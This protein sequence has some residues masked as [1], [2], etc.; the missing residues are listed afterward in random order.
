VYVLHRLGSRYRRGGEQFAIRLV[1]SPKHIGVDQPQDEFSPNMS[2][3]VRL[4][5]SNRPLD[6]VFS[7]GVDVTEAKALI[8]ARIRASVDLDSSDDFDLLSEKVLTKIDIKFA[9]QIPV[10]LGLKNLVHLV[11]EAPDEFRVG[12]NAL[13]I[14]L[15]KDELDAV[16]CLA[17]S[18]GSLTILCDLCVFGAESVRE[19]AFRRTRECSAVQ[20]ISGALKVAERFNDVK[21]DT[22]KE[23]SEARKRLGSL[24]SKTAKKL[25]SKA[26]DLDEVIDSC[27][28]ISRSGQ[29][30]VASQVLQSLFTVSALKQLSE[31]STP[32]NPESV[33]KLLEML[34]TPKLTLKSPRAVLLAL[35]ALH[36]DSEKVRK[37]WAKLPIDDIVLLSELSV[38]KPFLR[39]SSFSA[40]LLTII[41]TSIVSRKPLEGLALI[42]KF[43]H[44][45]ISSFEE[46]LKKRLGSTSAEA[47]LVRQYAAIIA[48][49]EISEIVK[50]EAE[51]AESMVSEATKARDQAIRESV[52]LKAEV[53]QLEDRLVQLRESKEGLREFEVHQAQ[54]DAAR[55][56]VD[57]AERLSN[58]LGEDPMPQDAL[59][60]IVEILQARIISFGVK[61]VGERG[62]KMASEHEFFDFEA[63]Q[64]PKEFLVVTPAYTDSIVASAVIR[65]GIGKAL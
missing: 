8:T 18:L 58:W 64:P 37:V 46:V 38:V 2:A 11:N 14:P 27:V 23:S 52:T 30:A 60:E 61:R 3:P 57:L 45:P 15:T 19:A 10:A 25:E 5:T 13:A 36:I 34:P 49:D 4:R 17:S 62:Q 31:Y 40:D 28:K 65:R 26:I 42:G 41:K 33:L 21:F 53:A 56:I 55:V 48:E 39:S 32:S 63:P 29:T 50:K 12:I 20:V 51:R 7:V 1:R 59:S 47:R 54:A 16:V 43:G 24:L 6:S 44:L 22:A 9:D 35:S